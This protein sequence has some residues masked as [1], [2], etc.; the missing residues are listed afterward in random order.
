MLR[1]GG[2]NVPVRLALLRI[3]VELVLL[4]LLSNLDHL[5]AHLQR[6]RRQENELIKKGKS[7]KEKG[8]VEKFVQMVKKL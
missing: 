7:K 6:K 3:L 1:L 5:D 2:G 4:H 8:K